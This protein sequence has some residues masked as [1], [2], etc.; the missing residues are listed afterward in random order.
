MIGAAVKMGG[1]D[2]HGAHGLQHDELNARVRL[3]QTLGLGARCARQANCGVAWR[4][5]S[6]HVVHHDAAGATDGSTR[7]PVKVAIDL[8]ANP[9]ACKERSHC[10]RAIDK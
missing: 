7:R 4:E 2:A 6:S 1:L 3:C 5:V 9:D 8:M 10:S